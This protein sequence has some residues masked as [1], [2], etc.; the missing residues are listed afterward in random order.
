M[1]KTITKKWKMN[2]YQSTILLNKAMYVY[3]MVTLGWA[4][5][6][7]PESAL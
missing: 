2:M 4:S 3:I 7:G 6:D 1:H 5:P